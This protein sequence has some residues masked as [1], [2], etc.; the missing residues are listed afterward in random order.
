MFKDFK[1]G[2]N[3]VKIRIGRVVTSLNNAGNDRV[4]GKRDGFR[5][6]RKVVAEE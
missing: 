3:D 1:S 4:F 6:E 2:R 5:I